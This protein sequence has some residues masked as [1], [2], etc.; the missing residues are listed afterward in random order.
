MEDMLSEF[1]LEGVDGGVKSLFS[2]GWIIEQTELAHG[3]S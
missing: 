3:W 2:S 1:L